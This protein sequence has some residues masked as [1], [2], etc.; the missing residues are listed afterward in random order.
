[1]QPR[2]CWIRVILGLGFQQVPWF[3]FIVGAGMDWWTGSF[4]LRYRSSLCLKLYI[5]FGLVRSN[6]NV[7]PN[8]LFFI[9]NTVFSKE[10][11][12]FLTVFEVFRKGLLLLFKYLGVVSLDPVHV[13]Y[14]DPKAPLAT[15]RHNNVVHVIPHVA[16]VSLEDGLILVEPKVRRYI[17]LTHELKKVNTLVPLL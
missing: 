2:D 14:A 3:Q 12:S 15:L 5:L 11:F 13:V 9:L 7:F 17:C 1:L 8:Y 6:L 10:G 4:T 16:I